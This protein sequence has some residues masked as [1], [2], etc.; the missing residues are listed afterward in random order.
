MFAS[1]RDACIY[2]YYSKIISEN[3]EHYYEYIKLDRSIAAYRSIG[4]ANYHFAAEV[5]KFARDNQPCMVLAFDVTGFFDNLNHKI[6]KRN[7]KSCLGTKTLPPDWMKVFRSLTSFHFIEAREIEVL[8]RAD[9]EDN[10]RPVHPILSLRDF[11]ARGGTIHPNKR[12]GVGIPQGTPIS[13]ALSNVYMMDFDRRIQKICEQSGAMY[14]RYSDDILIVCN[15]DDASQLEQAVHDLMVDIDLSLNERKTES[16]II[17]N[18]TSI[19]NVRFAQYLG[20]VFD[21]SSVSIRQSSV[22]RQ[23]RKLKKSLRRT[24]AKGRA[25]IESG[26]SDKIYTKKLQRR[27]SDVGVRNFISYGKRS[28]GQFDDGSTIRK[29]VSKFE[30]KAAREIARLRAVGGS[31]ERDD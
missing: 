15:E 27:F 12:P 23:W 22:S 14:R 30:R 26:R 28:A 18:T 2:A 13:A 6:L 3:L 10:S 11:K 17:D 24:E 20:F 29:Q 8:R 31:N 7:L 9:N 16:T 25:E 21:H 1:H 19:K 5:V 4:K